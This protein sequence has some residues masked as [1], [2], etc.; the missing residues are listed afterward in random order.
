MRWFYVPN[1]GKEGDQVG[2]RLAFEKFHAEGVFS[3]YTAY[4]YLVRNQALQNHQLA[5]DEFLREV[6]AFAPDVVFIQ[7]PGP[8]YPLDRTFLQKLK[9]APSRPRLVLYEEDPYDRYIKRLNPSIQAVIAE[10]DMCVIGGTG[11]LARMFREA[12][13][14]NIR[15][16]RH[17]F[18]TRRFGTDWQ[19]TSSRRHDAV[20]IANLTCLKRIPWLFLPGGR[21]RRQTAH[22]FYRQFGDRF[23]LY[24]SG[25]GWQGA[26]F[27]RGPVA[28]DRQGEVVRD[29]WMSVN[30][31][32]FDGIAMYTSDRFPISLA[33]GVPHITNH[34]PGYRHVYDGIPGLFVVE[35]P[36]EAVDV[37]LYIRSLPVER[38][39][40]LGLQAAA[41]AL[42]HLEVSVVYRDIVSLV[43]EQFFAQPRVPEA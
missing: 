28:Y 17:S 16:A 31:G 11:Y 40:E 4:S 39:N 35:S 19:P 38:R 32:Q 30:W 1:E 3:A 24:G 42:A 25:Q 15:F 13:G 10:A 22:A 36:A 2:V 14:R 9:A 12:G 34:Q 27:C 33:C 23:A 41:Y 43:A 37:A 6:S 26:P 29:A 18:D 21:Q 7:H 8:D 5:L 20:M